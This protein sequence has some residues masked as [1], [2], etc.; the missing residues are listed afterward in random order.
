MLIKI[1]LWEI[2]PA[3]ERLITERSTLVEWNRTNSSISRLIPSWLLTPFANTLL[4]VSLEM[5]GIHFL[6]FKF[7]K[8]LIFRYLNFFLGYDIEILKTHF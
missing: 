1:K 7:D 6:F 4:C 3:M 8:E 5:T 2:Y